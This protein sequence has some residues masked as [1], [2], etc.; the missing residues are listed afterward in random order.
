MRIE[1]CI[2]RQVA[3]PAVLPPHSQQNNFSSF[4]F[5]RKNLIQKSLLENLE[6][7]ILTA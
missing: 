4:Y 1:T 2:I 3:H 7:F 5:S 6:K